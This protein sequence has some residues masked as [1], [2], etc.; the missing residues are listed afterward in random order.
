MGQKD[1]QG[2]GSVGKGGENLR[3]GND[4]RLKSSVNSV[5]MMY[6]NVAGWSKGEV[7]S[8]VKSVDRNDFRAK[9][10]NY[11]NPDIACLVET[12]L[13]EGAEVEFDGFRWFGWNRSQLN[14]KAVRG[15]GCGNIS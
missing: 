8:S 10:I 6:W 3:M 15:S 7:F 1:V 12:W 2:R 4:D 9:G 14:R 5:S 13:K 11:Y